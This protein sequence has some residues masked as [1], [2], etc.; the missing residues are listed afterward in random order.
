M[1]LAATQTAALISICAVSHLRSLDCY[2]AYRASAAKRGKTRHVS[3]AV[4]RTDLTSFDL[5]TSK[6]PAIVDDADMEAQVAQYTR[7][8]E[9]F[10]KVNDE[11][12][13]LKKT[14][15]SLGRRCGVS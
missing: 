10:I 12:K 1:S 15:Q 3:T 11:L 7:G 6:V 2:S 4:F 9:Q 5:P 13:G 8:R 14:I